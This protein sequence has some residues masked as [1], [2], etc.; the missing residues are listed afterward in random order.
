MTATT[1]RYIRGSQVEKIANVQQK[2]IEY[3]L[4]QARKEG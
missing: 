2:R 3:R 4:E 1:R